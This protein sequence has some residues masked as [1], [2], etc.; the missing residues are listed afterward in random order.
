MVLGQICISEELER[1]K[2]H[3]DNIIAGIHFNNKKDNQKLKHSGKELI[4]TG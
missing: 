3:A 1:L 4:K 2:L